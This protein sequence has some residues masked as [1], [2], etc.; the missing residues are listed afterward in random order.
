M[1]HPNSMETFKRAAKVIPGGIYGHTSPAATLPEA[2][3]YYAESAQGCRYKDVD[4]HEYIDF[5]CGYGTI[6]LGY[7]HPV[8]E[9][10]V[11]KQK[12]KGTLFNHPTVHQPELAELFTELVNF[13]QWAVF[14]KNGSDMTTWAIQVARE[15]TKRKKILKVKDAYHGVDPWCNASTGGKIPEDTAH[16]HEFAWNDLNSLEHL[17]A[18]YRD[19]IA[20]II[21]TPYHHPT[22][23][24]QEMPTPGFHQTIR[25][26]CDEHGIVLILDDIRAGFRLTLHGSHTLFGFEPDLA[27]YCKAI[28]NGYTL[29]ATVG[30]D[31]LRIPATK[32]FLTGSYWN[33]ATAMAASIAT[34]QEMQRIQLPEQ[35]KQIGTQ[36][37]TGIQKLATKNGHSVTISGPPALPYLRFTHEHNFL[38]LQKLCGLAAQEGVILHPHHNWFLSGAHTPEDIDQALAAIDR[39][40]SQLSPNP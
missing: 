33:D 26:L 22:F 39:A 10:A 38:Q 34:L 9:E 20:A 40:F 37:T 2:F 31:H 35:L 4:G 36:F 8:V 3:P 18:K 15:H 16:I 29:S 27:C 32:V 21:L 23:G 19:E 12:E 24:D 25:K 30:K 1:P 5:L 13:A 7:K 11:A 17:L 28:G 6:S 14:G